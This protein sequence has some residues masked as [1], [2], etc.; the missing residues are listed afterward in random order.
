MFLLAIIYQRASKELTSML[1]VKTCCLLLALVLCLAT[2][3]CFTCEDPR[4][5]VYGAAPKLYGDLNRDFDDGPPHGAAEF[6]RIT[7]LNLPGTVFDDS[8]A[9]AESKRR[10]ADLL[11]PMV[12]PVTG[13]TNIDDGIQLRLQ[14]QES[15]QNAPQGPLVAK[16]PLKA[17]AQALS[18]AAIAS[19]QPSPPKISPLPDMLPARVW[20]PTFEG[21]SPQIIE[22]RCD[23]QL[24]NPRLHI[25]DLNELMYA[26]QLDQGQVNLIE[27]QTLRQTFAQFLSLDVR[28]KKDPYTRA[29]LTNDI[30][31]N[32]C[33]TMA[34]HQPDYVVF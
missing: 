8:L 5:Q 12:L 22:A 16:T 11:G 1:D 31:H 29:T 33:T 3:W 14:E 13:T 9:L 2:C 30:A 21:C 25:T 23:Y 7:A 28:S 24:P 20:T 15:G 6:E 18:D 32:T 10:G 4:I 27:P 26:R 34:K 19:A 17:T